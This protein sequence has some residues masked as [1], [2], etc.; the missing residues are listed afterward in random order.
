VAALELAFFHLCVGFNIKQ[1]GRTM[2]WSVDMLW[3]QLMFELS[4]KYKIDFLSFLLLAFFSISANI[5]NQP[6]TKI[7]SLSN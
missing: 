2:T 4:T 3:E 7:F 1:R 6:Q 5:S